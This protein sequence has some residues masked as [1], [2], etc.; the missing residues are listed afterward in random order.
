MSKPTTTLSRPRIAPDYRDLVIESLGDEVAVLEAALAV[1]RAE[2]AAYREVARAAVHAL[3]VVTA[4]CDRLRDE[5][6]ASP[7]ELESFEV[8][9]W[10]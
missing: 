5:L 8:P 2:C 4:D 10:A 7:S 1:A 3:H 9:S 6:R